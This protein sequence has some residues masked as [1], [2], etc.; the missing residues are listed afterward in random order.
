ML[1]NP[2]SLQNK[3]DHFGAVLEDADIDC[4]AVVESWMPAQRNNITAELRDK[5][6]SIYHFNRDNRKG[7]GVALIFRNHFKFIQG[8][9]FKS[10]YFECIH[11]SIACKNTPPVN[12]IVV[13]R[14]SEEY[15]SHFLT[16]FYPIIENMF[17]NFKN[18]VFLGDFNLHVNKKLDSNI[19]KFY[20]ILSTFNFTQ[21]IEGPTHESGNTLDLVIHDTCDTKVSDIY[22]DFNSKSDHALIFFKLDLDIDI[23]NQD[24]T[25]IFKDFKNVNIQDFKSDIS[26]NVQHYITNTDRSFANTVSDFNN[27]CNVCVDTHVLTKEVRIHN[28]PRPGW[29]D[30]EFVKTRANRRK[31]YKKWRRTRDATDRCDFESARDVTADM[32]HEKRCNFHATNIAKCNS[33]KELFD[34]CKNLLDQTG[35]SKLPSYTSPVALSETFNVYFIEK[36]EKIRKS[37]SEQPKVSTRGHG[38]DTYSGPIFSQFESITSDQLKKI[39]LSKPIKTSSQDPLPATLLKECLD[40]LLPALTVLVNQSLA[41][42]SMDG[43][44]DTVINPLLKKVGLDPEVLKNYRPVCNILYLSKAIERTVLLQSNV[45]LDLINGH[46]K[47]QS[48]YKPKHSCETLLIRVTNDIFIQLDGSK[49]TIMIL[50]DLSAAFDT[51]DHEELL[52]ILWYELGFRGMVFQ[53]FVEFLRDRRQAVSIDGKKSSFKENAFGV[54]QGSVIGPFLFNI[55]VRSLIKT[56]ERAGFTIHGYADDH[57]LLYSFQIDFQVAAI[58]KTVPLALDQVSRWMN[59][60]FLK[61][62][63]TKSQVIVFYPK[64]HLKDAVFDRLL[65]SDGSYIQ[66]SHQVL[67]LGLLI[68]AHLTFSPYVSAM[69]SQGYCL[70]RNICSVRKFL[71]IDHVKTLVNAIVIGKVD[72]CN[73]L[74][75][76]I[77]AYDTDRLQKFQ[78]SCARV[79]YKKRK[80]EHVS[81]ILRELHWLPSEARTYF[82]LL[83]CVYKCLHDLAPAYLS[84]LMVIRRESDLS[85][86]V[87]RVFTRMGDRAF[88]V[89][90]PRLWNAL[91]VEIR[92]LDTLSKFKSQL[93]HLFFSS[94]QHYKL[95]VNIYRS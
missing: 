2:R 82:K 85:L 9:T 11:V 7:G 70:L 13:Y 58:R 67:T 8:R 89:A 77:S 64:T 23:I 76:G 32:S 39:L 60:H 86:S 61:L 55:Y 87:P 10:E 35:P 20:D 3:F 74:L 75:Y 47:C 17:M 30:S 38:M 22:V 19:L 27:L 28:S 93:K 25:V 41:D 92:K 65:L 4:A 94:F 46:I 34:L 71:S 24:K 5:G 72:N 45:H 44:K 57:T 80:Y 31:L 59:K 1:Y 81:G 90:G 26:T 54:P 69:I 37:F 62:N 68:D 78:N 42:G 66:I 15:P 14:Y 73:S 36:I 43:L 91:P 6:Y 63:P 95:K 33:H 29:M 12:F 84:E 52:D 51:V 48:G 16:E 83:C 53:W 18:V 40:E 50:L 21:E 56:M 88:S 79:I 49:C